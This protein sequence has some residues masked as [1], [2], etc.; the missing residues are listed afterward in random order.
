M[1]PVAQLA[2]IRRLRRHESCGPAGGI[3]KYKFNQAILTRLVELETDYLLN[4]LGGGAERRE[5][6]KSNNKTKGKHR[7]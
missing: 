4:Q 3:E 5:T 6:N 1:N 2:I 7:P